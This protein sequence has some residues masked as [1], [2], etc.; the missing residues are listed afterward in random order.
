MN[1]NTYDVCKSL[2]SGGISGFLSL[3][4]TWSSLEAGLDKIDLASLLSIT[5][6][7]GYP[8]KPWTA[9]IIVTKIWTYG[10]PNS[11][12]LSPITIAATTPPAIG[13]AAAIE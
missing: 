11:A 10:I 3:T 7:T 4:T 6:Q 8:T 13:G 9:T 2:L 12:A 5:E 1:N